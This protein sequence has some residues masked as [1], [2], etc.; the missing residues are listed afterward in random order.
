MIGGNVKIKMADKSNLRVVMVTNM[1]PPYRIGM[2]EAINQRVEFTTLLDTVSEFNRSWDAGIDR[3]GFSVIVQNCRS[4]IYKRHR[5]D[6]G[7]I[8]ERQF[9]FSEKTFHCLQKLCPD[10]IVTIEYGLKTIWSLLYGKLFDVPVILASEGTFHT[11]GHVGWFKKLVRKVLVSQCDRFWSNGPESSKLLLS[12][13]AVVE[14]IDEGMTGIDTEEWR[15]AVEACLPE[16]NNIRQKWGLSGKVLL[17]SGSLSS[18]KGVIQLKDTLQRWLAQNPDAQIS[19][20]LLG[21]GEHMTQLKEW[22]LN[23][24]EANLVLP[25]F[26]QRH[27]LP[28]FFAAADWAVLPTLDDNWPLATLETL[29]AGLPQ[30]FSVYNGATRDLCRD[31]TG[32]EV[33]PLDQESFLRGFDRFYFSDGS[34]I[35]SQIIDDYSNYYSSEAQGSRAHESFHKCVGRQPKG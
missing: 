15:R 32:I 34:R 4:F 19:V 6:V 7:Y 9:Q 27:E 2:F 12:Y 26:V 21:D 23:H 25:G 35:P 17:L 18:R 5:D 13:G 31:E 11:E 10:V 3:L 33:D 30:I 28:S 16:R 24:P 22:S 20:I 8:E 1:L 14:Q 29:V